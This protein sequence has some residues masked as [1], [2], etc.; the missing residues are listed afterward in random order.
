MHI[1]SAIK[2]HWYLQKLHSEA[3]VELENGVVAVCDRREVAERADPVGQGGS[4]ESTDEH[5]AEHDDNADN[6]GL[7]SG[8]E[9]CAKQVAYRLKSERERERV[10]E[11][12][13]ND[14][15]GTKR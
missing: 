13:R 1:H 11:N 9:D 14:E 3:K 10:S 5:E 4:K 12:G 7:V 8:H 15:D 6:E 2:S